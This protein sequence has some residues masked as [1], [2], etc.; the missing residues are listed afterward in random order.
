MNVSA[1]N[2]SDP[3]YVMMRNPSAAM[4]EA[5]VP[6]PV[7]WD[8]SL[9]SNKG[10]WSTNGCRLKD[11]VQDNL[12]FVCK[13]L[14]YYSLMQD[15]TYLNSVQV[16]AKFKFSHPAIYVGSF[17][18][19]VSLLV[20]IMTY[21]LNYN[22]I[23]MP[24]KAKHALIN[25]WI[26][27]SLLCFMYVFGVYQ[28][29]NVKLCQTIGLILHY[30]T[31]CSL[32]WMCVGVNYMYKRLTKNDVTELQDDELPSD[33]P[34]QKPILG[35]YL[36][37]WGIALII[38]GIS[39]A[40][41]MKEYATHSHCFLNSV[42]SLSALFI[43]LFILLTFLFVFFL[44]IR[45]AIY[46]VDTNG[47]LSE[48]TQ[49]TENVDLD[50][51]EPNFPNTDARSI[52]SNSTKT[53]S[54]EVEDSEHAPSA[55]LKAYIVFLIIYLL[56][57]TSCALATMHPFKLFSYEEDIFSIAFAVF[58]T[59]LGAFTLF[60]Y[61][62]ARNDV[63]T[64]WVIFTRLLKRK[65]VC[66]RSRNVSDASP[67]VTQIQIHHAINNPLQDIQQQVNSRSSSRSSSHT[68]T[69]S[70]TSNVLKAAAD[71]NGSAYSDACGAK[72]NNVNLIVLH[73][74][75]YRMPHVVPNLIEN[76]T[77][78]AEMFYNPHQSTVA[79]K[80]FKKQ[81]RHM[82]KRNNLTS[83]MPR[84][85]NSDNASSVLSCP[86]QNKGNSNLNRNI[87]GNNSKVNN[88]NIHVEQVRKSKLRNPNILS[89]SC[90][91]YEGVNVIPVEKLVMN[92]EHLRKRDMAKHRSKKKQNVPSKEPVRENNMRSVSQQ[93]TLEYSSE[94][95]SDS[96]LD[97]T[98]PD[99]CL[100]IEDSFKLESGVSVRRPNSP[101]LTDD[102][103]YCKIASVP[104][105]KIAHENYYQNELLVDKFQ[106][107]ENWGESSSIIDSAASSRS[108][109]RIYVNPSHDLSFQKPVQ[110]R[111][112][113]V[114]AS[115]LDELYQQI[116]RG[117]KLKHGHSRK[118]N[119]KFIRPRA[120]CLSDS[121]INTY[122]NAKYRR[123]AAHS[124]DNIS[125]KI[126][127]TV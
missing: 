58:A 6:T 96:I 48:G 12:V 42:P 116:R 115:E 87:F 111:T 51:L 64:Q 90:E 122:V 19:I 101:A 65:N 66:F 73:R 43:P 3:V 103:H 30:L 127:T 40:V 18:L 16:G 109:P 107:Y 105:E 104:K 113:S 32:L 25:V 33:Q 31:L 53:A 17:I 68:K 83:T 39:G 47:H 27:I 26:A 119:C 124:D 61:C 36:V 71:L 93:C 23:Q 45:C 52:R 112:S 9:N 34:I 69:N 118:H 72:I 63:R 76:P 67:N 82:M 55:Q 89:D 10:S 120:P 60:F 29:E 108:V 91:E 41:N 81:K 117:P 98:S 121:E 102:S 21:L 49:A 78:S 22:S 8:S 77:S 11:E 125:D 100:P 114:S 74:Q 62:V 5:K 123:R 79:R 84:D 75:Q 56:T 80:F 38:C 110:S 46:N 59:T 88:T 35:L 50:L 95:I 20:A 14:G 13:H 4:L 97:K 44:L 1:A 70:H 54:S 106:K 99:K 2:L 126:E 28:T 92:A 24:K 57:W 37:G 94:T 7:W 86:K 85:V 15:I